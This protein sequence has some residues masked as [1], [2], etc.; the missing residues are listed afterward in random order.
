MVQKGKK[1]DQTKADKFSK[2]KSTRNNKDKLVG[3]DGESGNKVEAGHEYELL[4]MTA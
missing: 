2:S 3:Q 1:M 4:K